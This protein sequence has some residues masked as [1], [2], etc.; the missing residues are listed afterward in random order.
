MDSLN[1]NASGHGTVPFLPSNCLN[2][3]PG[4]PNIGTAVCGSCTMNLLSIGLLAIK[5]KTLTVTTADNRATVAWQ[6]EDESPGVVYE[7]QESGNGTNFSTVYTITNTTTSTPGKPY[8]YH[9]PQTLPGKRFYRLKITEYGNH[10][11]YSPIKTATPKGY[12]AMDVYPSIGSGNFM[13]SLPDNFI[14]GEIKIFTTTGSTVQTSRITTPIFRFTLNTGRG[15]Y[16][17][18]A[19]ATDGSTLVKTVMLQ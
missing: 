19:V 14:N 17:I 7:V 15:V 4:N 5:I 18:K 13:A 6:L 16:Y 2:Y 9:A 3:P 1:T 8:Q 10:I 11:E 12:S